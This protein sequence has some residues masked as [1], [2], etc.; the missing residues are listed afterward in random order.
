MESILNIEDIKLSDV[1]IINKKLKFESIFDLIN[2]LPED[3]K[4]KIYEEYVRIPY[5]KD[6]FYIEIK[7]R[8]SQ[9]LNGKD[10]YYRYMK[11]RKIPN[12]ISYTIKNDQLINNLYIKHYISNNKIFRNLD[13]NQSFILSILFSLYH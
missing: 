9:I 10:L 12:L 3:I 13:I 8:N 2:S 6:K 7:S 1:R 4:I 5:L 11:M